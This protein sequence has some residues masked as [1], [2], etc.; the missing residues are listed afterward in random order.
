MKPHDFSFDANFAEVDGQNLHYLDEGKGEV[1]LMVHGNPTWS[2]YYRNVVRALSADYRCIVPDHIGCGMS[3]KPSAEDYPYTLERR[4]SDLDA[5]MNRLAPTG[6]VHLVLHDWGGMIGMAWAARHRERIGRIVV[7]NTAA[8]PLPESKPFPWPLALCRSP[9]G[10]FII[11]HFNGFAR[12]ASRVAF[13]K[14]VPSEVRQ[15]YVWPYEPK[16]ARVATRRFVEDIPLSPKDPGYDVV[17]G[18]EAQLKAFDD[19]EVL[20]CWGMKDFVFDHHFLA[21]WRHHW[22]QAEVHEYADCGH[23]ILEDAAPE[24]IEKIRGFFP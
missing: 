20:V 13:K 17:A 12:V 16:G 10:G 19:R 5:L 7:L 18:V 14:S 4:V 6:K 1:V 22:P 3:A 23:Y 21:R 9:L 24:I 2:Y 15:A 8:F 11:E